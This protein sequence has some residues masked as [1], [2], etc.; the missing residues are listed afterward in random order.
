MPHPILDGPHVLSL[1]LIEQTIP[2]KVAGVYVLSAR[3]GNAINP[4]RIGRADEDLASALREFVGLYSH[5][6]C[7]AAQSPA[8]AYAMECELHHAWDLP[9]SPNHPAPPPNGDAVC[10]VCGR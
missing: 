8:S 9:E 2:R 3:E 5:F 1:R 7:A 10:P 4:R 6:S